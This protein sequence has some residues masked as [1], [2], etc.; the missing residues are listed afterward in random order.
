MVG[1]PVIINHKSLN[2]DNVNEERVGAVSNV[3]FDDKDGWY[4]CEGVIWDETAQNLITEQGWSVSCSY[5]VLKADDEGGSE[6]NIAYDMEFLDGVF[7][8]LALVNNP[9]YER[10]NIVFNSRENIEK[11]LEIYNGWVT[12]DKVDEEGNPIKVWIEGYYGEAAQEKSRKAEIL[13][14]YKEGSSTKYDFSHT[15]AN[16]TT[17]QQTLIKETINNILGEY[18]SKPIAQ[19]EVR[20]LGGGAL[21]L[22]TSS[23]NASVVGLS[24]SMFSGKY[25]QE[26]WENSIKEGFHPVTDNKDMITCVLTHEIG[27]AMSVN[28]DSKDFWADIEKIRKDYLENIKKEDIKNPDFISNYARVNK[29]EFVAEAFAQGYLSKKVGKYTSK[30]METMKK[31]FSKNTQLKL[32]ASNDKEEKDIITWEEDFGGGYPLD[33]KS[34]NKFKEKQK[35]AE[36]KKVDNA[37]LV[38]IKDILNKVK[39]PSRQDLKVIKGLKNI[40]NNIKE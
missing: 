40:I 9:R 35:K 14:N 10:A 39:E 20:T 4:W 33:E 8:H 6:N 30:V 12:L 16:I 2:D 21:G 11:G 5:D 34:Y 18:S 19:V 36:E 22:C 17:E 38:G 1:V 32:A 15:R 23:K 24:S 28:T 29:F 31:H 7:T 26:K 27:H 13:K 3:W 37:L 25:T